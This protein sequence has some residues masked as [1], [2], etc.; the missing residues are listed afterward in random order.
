MSRPSSS[1]NGCGRLAVGTRTPGG[2]CAEAARGQRRHLARCRAAST[3]AARMRSRMGSSERN[4]QRPELVAV[5][6]QTDGRVEEVA[7]Q[8]AQLLAPP[9]LRPVGHRL[10]CARRLHAVNGLLLLGGR[11]AWR[12][13]NCT[14]VSIEPHLPPSKRVGEIASPLQAPVAQPTPGAMVRDPRVR[15]PPGLRR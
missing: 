12:R 2:C 13:T 11:G 14:E 3:A 4:T 8:K 9:R 7:S 15:K 1:G 6:L 10:C 5:R